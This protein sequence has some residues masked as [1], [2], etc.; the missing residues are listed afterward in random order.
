VKVGVIAVGYK[1]EGHFMNALAPFVSMKHGVRSE[2]TNLLV[3]PP[4]E[5]EIYISVTT[6]L[7][8]EYADLG[9]I[10][11][12]GPTEDLIF[13]YTES[14]SIDDFNIIRNPPILDFQSRSASLRF[15]KEKNVDVIWQLDLLD[16]WYTRKEIEQTLDYIQEE[17]LYDYYKLPFKNYFGK[18]HERKYVANFCPVRIIW[19]NKN[20]GIKDFYWDNDIEFNNGKKTPFCAGKAVPSSICNP[21]HYSWIGNKET[22]QKKIAYQHKAINCCSYRWNEETDSLEFD[23]SY[24]ARTGQPQPEVFYDP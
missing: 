21:K 19:N 17:N 12:N 18:S 2:H 7:F 22:L 5:H 4:S 3:T 14:K 6:A 23:H 13:K 1:C 10:Y 20:G 16:E 15:L 9:D 11:D 8:K 24:Y